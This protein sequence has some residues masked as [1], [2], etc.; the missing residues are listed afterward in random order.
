MRI[1]KISSAI[2]ILS[3]LLSGC[4]T[5]GIG[6]S[7]YSCQ[8]MPEGV[9][10]M[11]ARDIYTATN[12]SDHVGPTDRKT[13]PAKAKLD[14]SVQKTMTGAIPRGV[15]DLTPITEAAVPVRS[16][17][18]VIRAWIAPWEDDDGYLHASEFV[19]AE[20]EGRRWSIGNQSFGD[21]SSLSKPLKTGAGV[22]SRD[23]AVSPLRGSTPSQAAGVR[24]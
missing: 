24:R 14:A 18:R 2:A 10:C 1:I 22:S 8:G 20:V 7:S 11:S 9:R 13:D 23:R 6:E 15:E 19:F 21:S 17:A 3:T 12:N 5:L 16:P 4:G